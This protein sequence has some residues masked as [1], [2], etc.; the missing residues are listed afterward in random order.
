MAIKVLIERTAVLGYEET[1]IETLRR[2]RSEAVRRR[3]YMYG[4][5]WRNADDHRTIVVLSVWGTREH[6]EEW[7]RSD[8]RRGLDTRMLS[9]LNGPATVKVY[10]DL[11]PEWA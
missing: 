2:L 1:V 11:L 7:Q 8:V 4:E 3:G 9:M 6:W 5:T 10:E